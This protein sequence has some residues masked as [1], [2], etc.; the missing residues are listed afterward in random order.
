MSMSMR[1]GGE[2]DGCAS[3]GDVAAS[4]RRD[5]ALREL[6]SRSPGPAGTDNSGCW[7]LAVSDQ[8][9]VDDACRP[10]GHVAVS[11]SSGHFSWLSLVVTSSWT[12]RGHFKRRLEDVVISERARSSRLDMTVISWSSRGHFPQ[13][14]LIVNDEHVEYLQSHQR[15]HC[16]EHQVAG[17]R[18][19]QVARNTR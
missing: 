10:S 17:R 7:L 18:H 4:N 14:R 11:R 1:Q 12:V 3:G 8:R 6:A 13:G 5:G 2:E 16:A 9:R 19:H 15:T